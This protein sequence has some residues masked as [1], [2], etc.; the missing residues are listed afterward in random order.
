M[1]YT[2]PL[3]YQP[4]EPDRSAASVANLIKVKAFLFNFE[5]ILVALFV[6]VGIFAAIRDNVPG[7]I[8]FTMRGASVMIYSLDD[9]IVWPI[10]EESIADAKA[11]AKPAEPSFIVEQH[12]HERLG[13][14]AVS[15]ISRSGYPL[16]GRDFMY[17]LI[18]LPYLI[19]LCLLPPAWWLWRR[20]RRRRLHRS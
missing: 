18:P 5:K 11:H 13:V 16:G 20:R 7:R 2:E 19:V 14:L 3:N 6:L 15:G 1:K 8:R 9:Q 4:R 17:V 10:I 12:Q